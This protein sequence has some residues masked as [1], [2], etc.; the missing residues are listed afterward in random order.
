MDHISDKSRFERMCS[1]SMVAGKYNVI[2]DA[3]TYTDHA[4]SKT[5]LQFPV[6]RTHRLLRCDRS[7]CA[8]GGDWLKIG[9][10]A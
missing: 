2:W 1:L 10:G 5:G 9:F 6:G 3:V 4:E 8:T 7:S